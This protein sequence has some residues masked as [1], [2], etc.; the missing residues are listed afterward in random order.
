MPLIEATLDKEH[1]REFY[2]ALMDYGSW[3]KANGVRNVAISKHYK[4]QSP[5][6][7]SL[8]ETRGEIV[9]QL[10]RGDTTIDELQKA[11]TVD[12]RFTPAL[13]G[14]QHDGLVMRTG[15]HFHLTK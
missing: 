15:A 10:A 8:R 12:K 3:L 4:K 11:M 6:K 14:L 1:P 5:L 7:G 13:E 9:R 2:W